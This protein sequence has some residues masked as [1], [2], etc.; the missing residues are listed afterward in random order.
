MPPEDVAIDESLMKFRGCLSHIQFNPSKCARFGI[1]LFKLCECDFGC[2]VN[3]K[4]YIDDDLLEGSDGM[5][6]KRLTC[7]H[8]NKSAHIVYTGR[9]AERTKKEKF[10]KLK[11]KM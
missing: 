6:A 1:K 8:Q 5:L 11:K 10:R 3:C 2:F 9:K 7:C 4:I